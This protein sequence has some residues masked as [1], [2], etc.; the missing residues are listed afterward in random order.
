[1][2]FP[3]MFL[4][5]LRLCQNRMELN[6]ESRAMSGFSVPPVSNPLVMLARSLPAIWALVLYVQTK[7]LI[8]VIN[9]VPGPSVVLT[10]GFP[11][12]AE[13]VLYICTECWHFQA[14]K[15]CRVS[16]GGLLPPEPCSGA[17]PCRYT[18]C[19]CPPPTSH[20]PQRTG[21]PA[22]KLTCSLS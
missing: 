2:Y 22:S 19:S 12:I 9:M 18:W 8:R 13:Q 1:M 14:V 10:L 21:H 4:L 5:S 15:L 7:R 16:S 17:S 20:F 6:A 11:H 3:Q